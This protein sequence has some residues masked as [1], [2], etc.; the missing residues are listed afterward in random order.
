MLINSRTAAAAVALSACIA[1]AACS[2][3]S[4]SRDA[5]KAGQP[6]VGGSKGTSVTKPGAAGT[7]SAVPGASGT[8]GVQGSKAPVAAA[9]HDGGCPVLKDVLLGALQGTEAGGRLA[10]PIEL[11]EVDCAEGYA[12][13]WT[14]SKN[15]TVQPAG[16]LFAYNTAT[17]RWEPK[18]TGTAIDCTAKHKVPAAIAQEFR[19]CR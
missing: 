18:D 8:P 2:S 19:G 11:S 4:E 17:K 1:V 10:Q 7:G 3:S 15:N 13:A 14:T 6:T 5:G 9:T 16:V 12:M